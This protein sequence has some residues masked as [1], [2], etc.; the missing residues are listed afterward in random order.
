MVDSKDQTKA[1]QAT[2]GATVD[3]QF[4][5]TRDWIAVAQSTNARD[6]YAKAL[7]VSLGAPL[8]TKNIS[9]LLAIMQLEGADRFAHN[10][11]ASV[12]N[13]PGATSGNSVGVKNYVD[14]AS[15]IGAY[16]QQWNR[17]FSR[18]ADALR[19][20]RTETITANDPDWGKYSGNAQNYGQRVLSIRDRF[21]GSNLSNPGTAGNTTSQTVGT[22]ANEVNAAHSEFAWLLG[23]PEMGPLLRQDMATPFTDAEWERRLHQTRWWKENSS[24]SRAWQMTLNND[25]ASAKETIGQQAANIQRIA[26]SLGIELPQLAILGYADQVMRFAWSDDQ[27]RRAIM[28]GVKLTGNDKGK[29]GLGEQQI[30]SMAEDYGIRLSDKAVA[31]YQTKVMSGLLDQETLQGD[32]AARAQTMFPSIADSIKRGHTVRQVLDPYLDSASQILGKDAAAMFNVSDPKWLR[33]IQDRDPQGGKLSQMSMADWNAMVM[34]DTRYG[35]DQ[36]TN[37]RNDAFALSQA[38]MSTFGSRA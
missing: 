25:P 36:T 1:E 33:P 19:Q 18:W 30:R 6:A 16:T 24:S 15:A 10:P 20:D 4:D 13:A 12:T 23:D 35:Y 11:L 26:A 21:L 37:A 38:L 5:P 2:I 14:A 34:K 22:G 7:L 9:F 8:S 17:V 28:A 29:A 27:L 32:F 31:D 3:P